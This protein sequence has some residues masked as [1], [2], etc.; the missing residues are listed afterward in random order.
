L[1]YELLAG[2][3]PVT[4]P[5]EGTDTSDVAA[6]LVEQIKNGFTSIEA[7]NSLVSRNI[8]ALVNRC[9][10]YEAR[11]RPRSIAEVRRQLLREARWPATLWRRVRTRPTASSL[12]ATVA[13]AAIVAAGLYY[14][15]LPPRSVAAYERG[16][17]SVSQG[18]LAAAA[19]YF[20][21]ALE[22]DP[23]LDEARYQRAIA[24]VRLG[25]IDV[26]KGDFYQLAQKGDAT[27]MA[28]L[29]YCFQLAKSTIASVPW[30]ER[31][32]QH[33]ASSTAIYNNL[34]AA[35]LAAQTQASRADRIKMAEGYLLKALDGGDSSNT[36]RLNL[37]RCAVEKSQVDPSYDP[38]AAWPHAYAILTASPNDDLVRFHVAAWHQAVQGW[39]SSAYGA[40][41]A[42]KPDS[43]NEPAALQ[44]FTHIADLSQKRLKVP[45]DD[46]SLTRKHYYLEPF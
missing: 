28:C 14:E 34:G 22:I 11:E 4:L 6:R 12:T 26:A 2:V 29:A 43:I 36:V 20:G 16:L 18:D 30:Y 24:E 5:K 13:A 42:R 23:S 31:A 9:L 33:G 39:K 46:A 10:S 25:R 27:S 37:V 8:G 32:V 19:M 17:V 3:P 41:A 1:L 15:S 35:Y 21:K 40:R 38:I 7:R 44:A 45:A